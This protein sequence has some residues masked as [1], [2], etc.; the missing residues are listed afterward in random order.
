MNRFARIGEIAE[1]YE[2]R[3]VMRSA[4]LEFPR[5]RGLTVERCA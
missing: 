3:W 2:Q 5:A 4:G 1:P